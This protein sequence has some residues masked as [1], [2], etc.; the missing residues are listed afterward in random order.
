MAPESRP[1]EAS[2]SFHYALDRHT[3]LDIIECNGDYDTFK[4]C[5][6]PSISAED[7]GYPD[8]IDDE[9][10]V[11][12]IKRDKLILESINAIERFCSLPVLYK[13]F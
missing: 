11:D 1:T 10:N 3:I 12:K 4:N 8:Y 9:G 7:R 6:L 13:F 2:A 5:V